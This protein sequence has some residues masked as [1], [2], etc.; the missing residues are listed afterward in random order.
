MPN[1]N[2]KENKLKRALVS[3]FRGVVKAVSKTWYVKSQ[4]KYIT[5][6]RLNLKNPVSYTEKLQFLR[7]YVYP[8]D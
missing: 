8:N 2:L 6:H 4:Y 1:P 3:P 7:L 5:H